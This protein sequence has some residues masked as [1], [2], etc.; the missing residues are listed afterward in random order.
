MIERVGI[1]GGG[2][3]GRIAAEYL[4]PGCEVLGYDKDP[5]VQFPDNVTP[6]TFTDVVRTDA[7]MAAVPAQALDTLAPQLADAM[8][9]STVIVWLGSV[10][11]YPRLVFERHGLLERPFLMAHHL[12]GPNTI[13]DGVGGKKT[14]VTEQHDPMASDLVG[15]WWELGMNIVLMTAEEHDKRMAR[16]QAIPFFIGKALKRLGL[17][18]D[19][20]ATHYYK[21]LLKMVEIETGH[22]QLVHDGVERLNRHAR[23]EREELLRYMLEDHISDIGGSE[24]LDLYPYS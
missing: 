18:D 19:L 2:A 10:M 6:A 15:R 16:I 5:A 23:R 21:L 20:L 8:P 11:E 24:A 17:E 7:V 22:T 9:K 3:F 12:F 1:I 13:A 14:I 4:A